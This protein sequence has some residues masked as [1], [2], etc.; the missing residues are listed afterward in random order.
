MLGFEHRQEAR[1]AQHFQNIN[2]NRYVKP[3]GIEPL[4]SLNCFS[5]DLKF[6][7]PTLLKHEKGFNKALR[8]VVPKVLGNLSE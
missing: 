4:W 8:G 1:I 2:T 3:K 6:H 7:R 5:D